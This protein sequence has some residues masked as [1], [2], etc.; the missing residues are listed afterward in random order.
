MRF[1]NTQLSLQHDE[2]GNEFLQY[3]EDTSE[4]KMKRKVFRAYKNIINVE[5]C[6]VELYKKYL[7]HVP[8]EI[9]DNAFYLR[10]LTKLQGDVW[11]YNNAMGRE[12]LGI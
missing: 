9:S 6:P 12:T 11:Y 3:L 7:S 2:S 8:K 10:A 1:K 4:T 5:R